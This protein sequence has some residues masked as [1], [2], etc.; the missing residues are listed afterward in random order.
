ANIFDSLT[1]PIRAADRH[2]QTRQIY[3]SGHPRRISLGEKPVRICDDA[4]IGAG[5]FVLR[6]VV[7][8]EGAVVAAGA[9]VT[10]DVPPHVIVAGNPAVVLRDLTADER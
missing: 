7:V 6:G 10:R 4:W 8:G 1:H 2:Q 3:R 9:V 5:A